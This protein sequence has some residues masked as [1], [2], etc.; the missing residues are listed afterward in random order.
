MKK[1]LLVILVLAI[2]GYAAYYILQS[3][4]LPKD[5]DSII[6][7]NEQSLEQVQENI[8]E[9]TQEIARRVPS[10]FAC[11]GEFCDGSGETDDPSQRTT[12]TVYIPLVQNGGTIGCGVDIFYAPHTV[13]K[14][15]GVL[16]ATYKLLFDIKMNPEITTDGFWN[17]VAGYTQLHY[18]HVVI[19]N[20]TAKVY[21][22]GNMY[23]PGHCSL[24]EVREQITKTALYYD[25]VDSVEV[26]VNEKIYD[27][28]EQDQSEGEGSCPENP[29]YWVVTR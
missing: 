17:S 6:E 1:I 12:T 20:A 13:P 3:N 7:N 5:F 21:L 4:P 22:T 16:D 23:G 19:E 14:T 18:D 8:T 11:V 9:Q 10:R 26:Y 2:G 25:T 29:D 24:P 27:W 15:T 28:C